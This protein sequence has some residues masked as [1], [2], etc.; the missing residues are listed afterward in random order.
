MNEMLIEKGQEVLSAM[1]EK[2]GLAADVSPMEP[3]GDAV[4]LDIQ[5]NQ[6]GRLIGRKGQNLESLELILNRIVRRELPAEECDAWISLNVDGYSV[7]HEAPE[8]KGRL[9]R[10]EMERLEN[11]AKDIAKEVIF[12][13]QDKVIGPYN[14]AERRIIHITL[15]ENPAVET[16]S[17][18]TADARG[19]K[20]M[21]IHFIG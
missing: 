6:S 7:P 4:R 18:E 16:V 19:C 2:L 14:P 17:E 9:P 20:K 12:L 10:Q 3:E 15:R 13:K 21:T 8:R 5:S 11:L 1:L